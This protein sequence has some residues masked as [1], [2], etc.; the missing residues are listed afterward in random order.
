MAGIPV[1]AL[2]RTFQDAIAVAR[3]LSIPY[4]WIDSLCIVQDSP[5]DWKQESGLMAS[6]YSN[7]YLNIAATGSSDS[8]QPFLSSRNPFHASVPV[9]GSLHSR[10]GGQKGSIL[11]R[12]S[13]SRVHKLY[14]SPS[15]TNNYWSSDPE[16][17]SQAPLLSRAWVF[18]ERHLAP[19]T[20]HFYPSELVME[21][22]AGL[23][24][25]CTGLDVFTSNPL[26]NFDDISF[27]SWFGV[28][29]DF[30]RLKLT[31]QSDRLPAL[32]GI[33]QIFW[34][35]LRCSYL[36]GIWEQDVAKGLLWDVTRYESSS[37]V[38]KK[39]DRLVAPSWSWASMVLAEGNRIF[40]PAGDDES[41]ISDHRFEYLGTDPPAE[42]P[43]SLFGCESGSILVKSAGVDALVCV[44]ASVAVEQH[45]VFLLFEND[46]EDF[47]LVTAIGMDTDVFPNFGDMLGDSFCVVSCL[48]IG[49]TK[50]NDVESSKPAT[51]YCML[52]LQPSLNISDGWER[53]GT[54]DI[55]EVHEIYGS[56]RITHFKLV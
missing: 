47:V 49:S 8:S 5:E 30:S 4:I 3:E 50:E 12:A 43:G 54:V 29:E 14:S 21:C 26:R 35:K 9:S 11:V 10:R 45:E 36:K 37:S 55:N 20:L 18:Q 19:R 27:S 13:M 2:P 56:L 1:G 31:Y 52:V 48:L 15:K 6:V 24:C 17:S 39:Q 25:E 7:S 41:Y 23:R 51:Y 40:F 22:R 28:V 32:M 53:I 46:I 16:E 38:T 34:E 44:T 42:L 33:A